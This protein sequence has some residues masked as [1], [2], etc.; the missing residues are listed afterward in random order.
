MY[1]YLRKNLERCLP[2]LILVNLAPT[3]KRDEAKW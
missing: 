1:I 3:V 2:D